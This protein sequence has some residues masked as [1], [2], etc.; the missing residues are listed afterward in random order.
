MTTDRFRE[1]AVRHARIIEDQKRVKTQVADL[2]LECFD[3]PSQ[4]GTSPR[5][6]VPK[7][8]KTFTTALSLFQPNDFDELVSER[9]IDDRCGYALCL[10]PNQKACHGGLKVWN[11]KGG[12]GFKLVDRAELERWCSK[13]CRHRGEFVRAQLSTEPAW[14]RD[15]TETNV[16][17][18][19]DMQR[20]DDIVAA[21]KD[22]SIAEPAKDVL[23]AKLKELS[24][25]RGDEGKPS[26]TTIDII[27]KDGA[28]A[29]AEAP[30]ALVADGVE[31][32][33][34][35]QVRFG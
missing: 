26:T 30:S 22:L 1:T 13:E 5:N 8:L 28:N 21:I 25:E 15:V 4:Q 27:E 9:N 12:S 34:V 17:L 33:Q 20:N 32:H 6:P 24:L 7:D 14:V 29:V 19:D 35:R 3:L 31:G 16:T 11:G 18:L 10:N 2:V 23:E